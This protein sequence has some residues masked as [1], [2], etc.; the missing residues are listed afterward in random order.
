MSDDP[1]DETDKPSEETLLE[2]WQTRFGEEKETKKGV[3]YWSLDVREYKEAFS[4]LLNSMLYA[5]YVESDVRSSVFLN[6]L[7]DFVTNDQI[8]TAAKLKDW[9][10]MVEVTW[11]WVV[12][13]HFAD[14]ALVKPATNF[15]AEE[16]LKAQAKAD[17]R[18]KMT[19]EQIAAEE[20]P[21]EPYVSPP[22]VISPDAVGYGDAE[23]VYNDDLKKL[24]EK[25]KNE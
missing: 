4:S 25:L 17:A 8:T 22:N 24:F 3:P 12:S 13:R 20:A 10:R 7:K 1:K 23:I 11:K 5:G 21:P 14:P 16:I 19:A 9:K 18:A 15:V 2:S 6:K